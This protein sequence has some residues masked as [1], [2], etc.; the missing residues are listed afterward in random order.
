MERV[1]HVP[2]RKKFLKAA[3]WR[4]TERAVKAL[5]EFL[6]RHMKSDKI[7]IDPETNKLL[8][9]HGIKNPP[10]HLKV[11]ALKEED[12][13]IRVE[14]LVK[15]KKAEEKI[16][17]KEIKEK[18]EE[19]GGEEEGKK[20]LAEEN[21]EETEKRSK[22]KNKEKIKKETAEKSK[23]RKSKKREKES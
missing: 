14:L 22:E 11:K 20:E 6:I 9:Q 1:Y 4:R 2:L 16:E 3:R 12:G 15:K 13:T 23:T 21:L 8:W 5:R 10:H 18:I 7:K 19:K 17:K